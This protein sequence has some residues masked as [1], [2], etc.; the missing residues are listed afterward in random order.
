MI[1]SLVIGNESPIIFDNPIYA[2]VLPGQP[3]T[4]GGAKTKPRKNSYEARTVAQLKDIAAKRSIKGYS[5][6]KKPE[7]IAALR[8]K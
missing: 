4:Q 3:Q 8:K 5:K 6:M 1:N 7:L 2:H